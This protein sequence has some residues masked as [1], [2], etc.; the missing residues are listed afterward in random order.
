MAFVMCQAVSQRRL[1]VDSGL[2]A[3]ST[4]LS[5]G[6][7]A[8]DWATNNV[9]VNDSSEKNLRSNIRVSFDTVQYDNEKQNKSYSIS[10]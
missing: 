1:A 10:S 3:E 6:K 2:Y 8:G 5:E 7:L 4:A 9:K